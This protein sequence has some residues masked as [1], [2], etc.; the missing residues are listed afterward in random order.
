MTELRHHFTV[1]VEE[2]FHASAFERFLPRSSWGSLET[3]L[4]HVL[5]RL[6]ENLEG[7]GTV[8]TFFVLGIVAKRH[9][10]LVRLLADNGHEVASHGWDHRRVTELSPRE[11]RTQVRDSRTLLQDL[12]GQAVNG[13]RAP[14]FSIVPGGEWALEILVEEGYRYDSSLYPVRRTGYG[15]PGGC[16]DV[17]RLEL[18]AGPLMEVP[19][20]TLRLGGANLPAGGGGTFRQFP[21]AMTRWAFQGA[22]DRKE[23]TTFYLHPWELDPEHPVVQGIPWLTRLRHYRGLD[24]VDPRLGALFKDFRFQPI[25]QTLRERGCL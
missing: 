10:D 11:F 5:P 22:S 17:H 24:R 20:A 4:P 6:L 13:F 16:R 1:D 3:R 25:E 8:G 2:Y 15:Y 21:Y 9:P 7:D 23:P 18:K 12:T 19:P 14:S